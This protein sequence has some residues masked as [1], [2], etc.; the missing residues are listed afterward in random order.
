MQLGCAGVGGARVLRCANSALDLC[1]RDRFDQIVLSLGGNA[2]D[3]A[4]LVRTFAAR[5]SHAAL[6]VITDQGSLSSAVEMMRCGA[7][8]V[9][10]KP[11]SASQLLAS[12]R[13]FAGT[14][15]APEALQ[16]PAGVTSDGPGGMIG[17][18]PAMRELYRSI[19]QAAASK[20]TVFLHGESGTGKEHCAEAVHALSPRAKGPL[21]SINCSAI[22]RELMESEIFGHERGAY[23]GA[24]EERKGAAE[25]AE[26]GTLFLDEVCEMDLALQ[27]KLLRFIQTGRFSRVGGSRELAVDVRFVCATNK[28]PMIAVQRGE[29]RAD[30]YYRLHVL[31]VSLPP[32]RTR[33]HDILDIAGHALTRFA[34]EESKGFSA[35]DTEAEQMLLAYDWPGNVRELL[36]VV[37]NVVVM[38]DGDVVSVDMLPPPLMRTA[39]SSAQEN[40]T[41]VPYGITTETD[42]GATNPSSEAILKPLWQHEQEIIEQAITL[43]RGNVGAAAMHLEISP[44]TIYRKRHH[45]TQAGAA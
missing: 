10:I 13:R 16:R 34:A 45:W 23:T 2:H 12:L 18:S 36:N 35:F 38:N 26:G 17:S 43:C 14:A 29:F 41:V 39:H 27:A 44:S 37:R 8:D 40:G 21:I 32:L 22:P 33:E 9:L 3:N 4:A 5:Q 24:H 31:P 42:G 15:P 11:A 30:L 20:A 1:E 19:E 7:S 28:D 25:L 6:I